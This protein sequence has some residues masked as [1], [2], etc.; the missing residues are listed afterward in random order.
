[1]VYTGKG[2]RGR[3]DLSSGERVSKSSE[4]IEAYGTVDELNS[5]VGVAAAHCERKHDELEEVQNEL[6]I[7]QAELANR[8]PDTKV[9][10]ENVDRL[11]DLCDE[12]Q[13][14][15]PPLRSFVLAGGTE[16]AS[17]LHLARSVARRAERRIV[18]LDQH[19]QLRQQVL[20]YINRLSDLFF[21]MARHENHLD[22]VEEKSPK[23]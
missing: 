3:T 17:Q 13:E 14:E 7:L 11:E 22:G 12:Y 9:T 20:A 6:H 16:A 5:V 8:N 23:Y 15:C 2:D 1:M 19:E 18:E 10:E 4:R 21:L